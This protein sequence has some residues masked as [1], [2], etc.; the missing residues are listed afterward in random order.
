M[1]FS[2]WQWQLFGGGVEGVVNMENSNVIGML[3]PG[4]YLFVS[5]VAE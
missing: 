4:R 2:A 5:I 3:Q 1:F